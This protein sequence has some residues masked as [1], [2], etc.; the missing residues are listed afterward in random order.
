MTMNKFTTARIARS[1]IIA[2]GT[3]MLTAPLASQADNSDAAMDSCI[4]AFVSANLPKQQ[5][6]TVRKDDGVASPISIHA[7][8]YKIVVTAK[9]LESGKYLARGTCIVDRSGSVIALNGKPLTTQL[10]SR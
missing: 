3:V 5:P 8:A 4:K 2:A 7:R 10:A 1:F 6:I 9:G